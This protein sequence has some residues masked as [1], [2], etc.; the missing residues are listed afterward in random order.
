MKPW[1]VRI[2]DSTIDKLESKHGVHPEDVY[3]GI[4]NATE[5]RKSR[6][7]FST[8]SRTDAG[9][10]IRIVVERLPDAWV[11]ITAWWI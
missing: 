11:V 8:D 6:G 10:R 2:S 1:P 9:R 3:Q 7:R 4:M 5:W